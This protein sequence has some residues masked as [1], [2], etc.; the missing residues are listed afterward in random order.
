MTAIHAQ[1]E[2]KRQDR[3]V[4][5]AEKHRRRSRTVPLRGLIRPVF[6]ACA[7]SDAAQGAK[8]LSGGRIQATL[9]SEGTATWG[10]SDKAASCRTVA[11]ND[12]CDMSELA[13]E[14]DF[15]DFLKVDIRVGTVV[16]AE[17]FPEARKPAI[18]LRID[19]GLAIGIKKSSA[20]ITVHYEP[21]QLVGQQV[22]AVV[23]FPPRQIGKFMSEVLTLGFED[24]NGAIVLMQPER[25]VPIGARMM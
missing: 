12:W 18:K 9:A 13:S 4:G 24:E 11:D 3:S 14:I 19:F 10:M 1:T 21:E 25:P 16:E 2:R 6:A 8:R 15:S 23:N 7:A 22:I 20:Q 5:R 17:P